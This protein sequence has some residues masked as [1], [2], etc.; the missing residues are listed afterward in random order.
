LKRKGCRKRIES[1]RP[2]SLKK[3]IEQE[4]E[5]EIG[6]LENSEFLKVGE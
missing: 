1:K 6:G 4:E 5:L 2:F 3:K